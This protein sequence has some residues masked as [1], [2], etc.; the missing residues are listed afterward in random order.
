MLLKLVEVLVPEPFVFVNPP[1]HL[2]KRFTSKR[3]E[4]FTTL[5][6]AFNQSSPFEKLQ[7]FGHSIESSVEWFCDIQKSRRPMGELPDDCSPGRVRNRRQ[8]IG[9]GIHRHT[10]HHKV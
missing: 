4:D 6:P 8:Y 1:G 9:E 10:L 2:A 3:Y 5:F 7:V